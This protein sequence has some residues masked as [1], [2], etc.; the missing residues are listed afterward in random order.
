MPFLAPTTSQDASL[1]GTDRFMNTSPGMEGLEARFAAPLPIRGL[2]GIMTE[3]IDS[4]VMPDRQQVHR[5][6]EAYMGRLGMRQTKQRRIILDAVLNL[7]SHVDAEAI[8]SEVR[9]VDEA[10]GLATVYRTL[11]LML[12]AGIVVERKFDRDRAHFELNDSLT[13]HHDHLI[14]VKC[15]KIIEFFD[16]E[17]EILQEKIASRL[18]FRL[19]DH[20]LELF[21]DCRG[22]CKKGEG[23]A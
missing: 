16:E 4:K 15:G 6:F 12:G 22:A 2:F 17:L 3:L 21:G 11:Q 10:I 9:K 23:R 14:C 7:G 19:T 5:V 8:S 18:G 20:R 13:R 1:C